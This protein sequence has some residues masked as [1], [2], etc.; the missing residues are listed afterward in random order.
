MAPTS[1]HREPASTQP[2]VP[3]RTRP[4]ARGPTCHALVAVRAGD[5]DQGDASYAGE[6][7]TVTD[8]RLLQAGSTYLRTTANS[9]DKVKRSLLLLGNMAAKMSVNRP[10][11]GGERR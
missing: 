4:G 3:P 11:E 6:G 9:L 7:E 5:A 2:S 10:D 8:D 1:D